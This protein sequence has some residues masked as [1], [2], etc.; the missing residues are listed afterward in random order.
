MELFFF[1]QIMEVVTTFILGA[2]LWMLFYFG[3]KRYMLDMIF[4]YVFYFCLLILSLKPIRMIN[5]QFFISLIF[6][7]QLFMAGYLIKSL[8]SFYDKKTPFLSKVL[9]GGIAIITF[10]VAGLTDQIME[11]EGFGYVIVGI[12]YVFVGIGWVINKQRHI[13][14]TKYIGF[15]FIVLGIHMVDFIFIQYTVDL[16]VYGYFFAA[17]LESILSLSLVIA[18][19]SDIYQ[20]N[21]EQY[22]KYQNLFD[23]SS[24]AIMILENNKIIDCNQTTL[25]LFE[26]TRDDITGSTPMKYSPEY[27][28]N[29]RKSEEYGM[30]LM[31]NSSLG[32]VDYFDWI[33]QST[34]GRI[35]QCEVAIFPIS[36]TTI[37]AITRDVTFK[38]TQEEELKF[39]KY[40]DTLTKLPKRELFVDRLERYL[41]ERRDSVAL[42]ALDIDNFKGINDEYGHEFGDILLQEVAQRIL[43]IFRKEVTMTR[44][45]GDEFILIMDHLIHFN[46]VY[47]PIEKIESIFR[48]VF[49]VNGVQIHITVSI[50]IAFP[51]SAEDNA[52]DLLRN[53]DL[54]LNI[55]KKRGRG[56]LE[57]YSKLG[58]DDFGNRV[59]LERKM[60]QGIRNNEFIPYYQPIINPYTNQIIGAEALMRWSGSDGT[61]IYPDIFIPIAEET[62]L[63]KVMGDRILEQA[64]THCNM[65]L[66]INPDFIINVNLSPIQLT[67]FTIVDKIKDLLEKTQLPARHLEIELTESAFIKDE[68]HI[69]EVI[70]KIRSLGVQVALD[71][72]GTGYSSLSYLRNMNVDT[73][74][75]DR[76]FIIR[77]PRDKKSNAMVTS[78][79]QLVHDLEYKVV[80]EGVEE[81]DQVDFLMD[82][83]S[84]YLQG[85]FYCRP[86]SLDDLV[87]LMKKQ[88]QRV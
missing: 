5:E 50:G 18:F 80:V 12:V 46:R 40:Y 35:I 38:I 26:A 15:V 64:C 73:I 47:L 25:K 7:L 8:Y 4:A 69:K 84:D 2:V 30:E 13:K 37:A 63:I 58:M 48:E 62:G 22:E 44:L 39:H 14:L 16:L 53:V 60:R 36:P 55:A 61:M 52:H 24:D 78:I 10:F 87:V 9:F 79:I 54:A 86:I 51:E 56:Q 17:I 19:F 74:K 70:H 11:I 27:Q 65:L 34:S 72:F 43:H 23:R 21:Q 3:K 77:I 88:K 68:S 82:Q 76:S 1:S 6:A 57:F 28:E 29:G 81:Q 32:D 42:I 49:V 85:Y 45:G 20:K 75:I 41:E 31:K 67:D 33:H 59:T 71:D 83:H 66:E